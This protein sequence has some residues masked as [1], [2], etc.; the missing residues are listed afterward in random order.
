MSKDNCQWLLPQNAGG[1]KNAQGKIPGELR[2][3][4]RQIVV[5]DKISCWIYCMPSN[6]ANCR[7]SEEC[8]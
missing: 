2:K 8:G 6:Q 3:Q 4:N 5:W 7:L 1:K